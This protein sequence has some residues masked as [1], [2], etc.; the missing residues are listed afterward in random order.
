[1]RGNEL[2]KKQHFLVKIGYNLYIVKKLVEKYKFTLIVIN[3]IKQ[4]YYDMVIR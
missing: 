4:S 3:V 2:Q 1:M